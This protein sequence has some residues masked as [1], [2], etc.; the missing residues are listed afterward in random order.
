MA[1]REVVDK[2]EIQASY[3]PVL[4]KPGYHCRP[5]IEC[6]SCYSMEQ[7]KNVK[8]FTIWVD[9]V[10]EIEWEEDV[11]LRELNLDNLITI[12]QNVIEVGLV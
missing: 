10:G 3:C 4:T 12:Q 8:G 2:S 7:L 9:N 1:E 5:S 6:L 11:D